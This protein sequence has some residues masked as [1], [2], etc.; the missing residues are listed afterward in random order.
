MRFIEEHLMHL[1]AWAE[2]GTSC[3]VL[4]LKHSKMVFPL[5]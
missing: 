1:T 4:Q 2:E 5:K 3:V